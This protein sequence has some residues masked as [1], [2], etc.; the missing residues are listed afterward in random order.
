MKIHYF[1]RYH[2]KENV[3]TGNAMLLLS[4]LYHFSS[5][6]FH[7]FIKSLVGGDI[8]NFETGIIFDMQIKSKGSVP[9]GQIK[10]NS[11]N[12]VIETK[13]GKD[14]DI[15]QVKQHL[16]TFKE[17]DY[18]VMLTL[19]PYPLSTQQ[20][21]EIRQA[22]ETENQTFHKNIKHVHSTFERIIS[23]VSDV[24]DERD[25]EFNDILNDYREYC[26][27]EGLLSN[28]DQMMRTVPVG[29]TYDDN[30]KYKLYYDPAARGYSEHG[31]IALYKEKAI[32]A[33]GKIV[34]IV[35]ADEVNGQL[36]VKSQT[37]AVTPEQQ[38]NIL[39]A[40]NSSRGYGWKVE[41]DHKFFCVDEF[42]ETNFAKASKYPLQGTK[43]FNLEELLGP[44]VEKSSRNIAKL[45]DGEAWH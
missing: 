42:V 24:I 28:R 10:Q 35:E 36:I 3:T 31:Y 45:L 33:V 4:R 40:I 29:R 38:N 7:T 2:S 22:I 17:E 11:F 13:L 14:F 27:H 9:D 25:Y 43:F 32:K 5:S 20:E 15:N 30:L 26:S 16:K 21:T 1:Q 34:N 18:Q 19:S 37:A 12:V 44:S 39:E 8:Q 23:L 6:K 41:K